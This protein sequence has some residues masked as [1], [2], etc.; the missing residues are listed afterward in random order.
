MVA[1][2]SGFPKSTT[3]EGALIEAFQGLNAAQIAALL[4][5]ANLER[6]LDTFT[7]DSGTGFLRFGGQIPIT[8]AI[9]ATT[10]KLEITALSK[11]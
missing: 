11:F 3:L 7:P 8:S 9:N 1:I 2:P 4:T 6:Y 10:G 5:N